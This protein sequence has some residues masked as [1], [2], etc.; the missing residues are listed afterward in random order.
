MDEIMT[1]AKHRADVFRVR[2]VLVATLTGRSAR[3]AKDTFGAGFDVFAVSNPTTAYERG[4]VY[5]KGMD[6]DTR[7]SLEAEGIRVVLADQGLFQALTIGGQPY[8]VG[9]DLPSDV[10][11]GA[12][13]T[14]SDWRFLG[15]LGETA[16]LCIEGQTSALWLMAHALGSILGDGPCVCIE[17]VLMAA[18]SGMLPLDEDCIAVARPHAESHAPDAALVVHPQTA[19]AFLSVFRIKDLVLVPK[20]GDNW[21]ADRPL[22]PNG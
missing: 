4:L 13:K 21:F 10:W 15:D 3:L 16:R 11:R 19:R 20:E 8:N 9:A 17:I 12:H 6:E 18:D 22:W 1:A 2:N 14:F 7:R 5:H